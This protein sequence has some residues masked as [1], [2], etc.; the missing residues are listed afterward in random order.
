MPNRKNILKILHRSDRNILNTFFRFVISSS[1]VR[2]L[3]LII[4]QNGMSNSERYAPFVS[5]VCPHTVPPFVHYL[6]IH[7]FYEYFC[8]VPLPDKTYTTPKQ[9]RHSSRSRRFVVFM[10][11]M[12]FSRD[13]LSH[14][15]CKI[16]YC[17]NIGFSNS[18]LRRYSAH[19]CTSHR[20]SMPQRIRNFGE[21][22]WKFILFTR[23]LC[24]QKLEKSLEKSLEHMSK[25]QSPGQTF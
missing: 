22:C 23:T 17:H 5:V 8:I 14:V 15:Y 11:C 10:K 16:C 3:P 4:E 24:D 21:L 9:S 1:G 25:C 19:T 7:H 12:P 13:A 20:L 18:Q 2:I 6:S